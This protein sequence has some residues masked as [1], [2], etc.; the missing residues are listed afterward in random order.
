FGGADNI[1]TSANVLHALVVI[2]GQ[3]AQQASQLT[4][5][6][7]RLVRTLGG[8]L[9]LGWSQVNLNVITGNP[10]P[11]SEDY[12]GFPVMHYIDS[13]TC[14]PIT[15]CYPSPFQLAMDDAAAISSLYPVTA[16]NQ[17][18]FPGKQIFSAVT[19]R[20]HGTVWF[21][22]ASGKSVQP[23]QGVNV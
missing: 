13:P 10:A 9:G 22:N 2:N 11:T 1:G 16:Q 3:C 4:D 20:I 14:V 7:Y 21:T 5:V 19:A 18:S 15:L 17:A 12:A 6:E 23:M 8:G